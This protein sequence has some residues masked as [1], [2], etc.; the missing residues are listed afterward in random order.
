MGVRHQVRKT[1]GRYKQPLSCLTTGCCASRVGLD[2]A[3]QLC[4]KLTEVMA[5]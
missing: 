2:V 4:G 5:L 3:G 1:L